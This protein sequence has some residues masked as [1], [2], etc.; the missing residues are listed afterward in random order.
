MP[1]MTVWL[2]VFCQRRNF[3]AFRFLPKKELMGLWAFRF[4]PKKEHE[5]FPI[6]N[7]R[8]KLRTFWFLLKREAWRLSGF[9]KKELLGF[10]IPICRSARGDTA[11]FTCSTAWKKIISEAFSSSLMGQFHEICFLPFTSYVTNQNIERRLFYQ[12]FFFYVGGDCCTYSGKVLVVWE[13]NL[14]EPFNPGWKVALT[15]GMVGVPLTSACSTC[16]REKV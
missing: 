11:M 12:L 2:S 13:K 4:L 15:K 16:Q 5:G 9:L 3:R 1:K 14:S 7:K 8:R 6:S 10:P